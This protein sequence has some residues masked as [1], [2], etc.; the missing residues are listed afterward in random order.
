MDGIQHKV[1]INSQP[2]IET[3]IFH[4]YITMQGD[5]SL[6]LVDGG[7]ETVH[8]SPNMYE[9]LYIINLGCENYPL[10]YVKVKTRPIKC[11]VNKRQLA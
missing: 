6:K 10:S 8:I 9:H 3:V 2:E 5:L 7:T 4:I 1:Y 11:F